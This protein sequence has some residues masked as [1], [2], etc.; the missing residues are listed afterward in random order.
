MDD[1]SELHDEAA[2]I[3]PSTTS[4]IRLPRTS[5]IP[6]ALIILL[7]AAAVVITVAGVRA[8]AWLVGPLLLALIVVIAVYPIKT[9]LVRKGWPAWAAV[10]SLIVVIYG[11]LVVLAAFLVVSASQL[12]ALLSQNAAKAQQLVESLTAQLAKIGI[13][14]TQAGATANSANLSKLATEIGSVLSGLGSF[15]SSLV[16]ILALLLFLTAESGGTS[17]RM[18]MIG[19]SART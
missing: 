17:R 13:D 1:M 10:L 15:L 14:P 19:P 6:R 9:W 11:T 16:F 4:G 2:D 12:A 7:G 8:V 3:R 5:A 18:N